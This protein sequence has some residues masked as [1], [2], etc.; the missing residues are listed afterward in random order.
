ML[1]V[2]EAFVLMIESSS[3][4]IG[5]TDMDFCHPND[6]ASLPPLVATTVDAAV[7]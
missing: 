7:S 1:E 6:S 2:E 5:L 3:S 4:S